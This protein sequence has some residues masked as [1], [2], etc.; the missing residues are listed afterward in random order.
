[1]KPR[2]GSNQFKGAVISIDAFFALLLV[3]LVFSIGLIAVGT[4]AKRYSLAG[5]SSAR[6]LTL[7]ISADRFVKEE[8]ARSDS[9]RI[10]QHEID[11]NKI[12]KFD[13]NEWKNKTGSTNLSVKVKRSEKI[14]AS[15]GNPGNFSDCIKRL[16]LVDGEAGILEVCA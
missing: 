12:K 13:L 9:E 6:E 7:I 8:L 15:A 1:M 5:D 4:L 10:F 11:L 16:V 2:H 14:I 3:L